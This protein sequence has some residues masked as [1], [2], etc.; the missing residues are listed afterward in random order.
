MMKLIKLNSES[1]GRQNFCK[2]MVNLFVIPNLFSTI[3]IF[4]VFTGCSEGVF[5]SKGD[6][7]SMVRHTLS[8]CQNLAMCSHDA[9]DAGY[10]CAMRATWALCGRDARYARAPCVGCTRYARVFTLCIHYVGAAT[11]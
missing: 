1:L 11:G 7:K 8:R 5:F 10:A 2:D 4:S 9:H 3:F 6:R